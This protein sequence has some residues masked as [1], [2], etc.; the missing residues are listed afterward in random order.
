MTATRCR[1]GNLLAQNL[2]EHWSQLLK[3][4]P[5]R[6]EAEFAD[7]GKVKEFERARFLLGKRGPL[8][9]RK[10]CMLGVTIT[11]LAQRSPDHPPAGLLL[12]AS[13]AH[14]QDR[15]RLRNLSTMEIDNDH[16]HRPRPRIL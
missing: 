13:L 1:S 11:S 2:D 7:A 3:G 4:S 14:H 16:H 8:G 15:P 10:L 5:A 9:S 6:I 12:L